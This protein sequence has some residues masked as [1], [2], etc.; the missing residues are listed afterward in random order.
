MH[1]V[2]LADEQS[3]EFVQQVAG[4]EGRLGAEEP[5]GLALSPD[6]P[7]DPKKWG[8][9]A[10]GCAKQSWHVK[11]LKQVLIMIAIPIGLLIS[12]FIFIALELRNAPHAYQDE[13]G[14]HVQGQTDRVHSQSQ[15]GNLSAMNASLS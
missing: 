12:G 14:F 5:V 8:L 6:T 10:S 1:P 7:R 3:A 9:R 15:A 11:C 4:L 2:P 13:T